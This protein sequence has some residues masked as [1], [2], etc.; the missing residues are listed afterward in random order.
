MAMQP[1]HDKVWISSYKPLS[2]L[3]HYFS[4]NSSIPRSSEV[5]SIEANVWEQPCR[6]GLGGPGGREAGHEPAVCT[7]SPEDL[8][9]FGLHWKRSGQQGEGGDC[10]PLL[11]SWEAPSG[12]LCLQYRKDVELSEQVQSRATK[13][14]RGLEHLSYEERLRELGLFGLQK[15]LRRPHCGLPVLEVSV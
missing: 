13:M 15:S 10:A 3:K 9:Y 6:E 2:I 1:T 7:C 5:H 14:I 8:L 11:S 4:C 12:V